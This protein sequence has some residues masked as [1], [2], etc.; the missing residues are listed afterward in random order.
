MV[1]MI[2]SISSIF[3]K[4]DYFIATY[5][6]CNLPANTL[7]KPPLPNNLQL[8][9]RSSGYIYYKSIKIS[10]NY[11]NNIANSAIYFLLFYILLS[12]FIFNVFKSW[13]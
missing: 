13:I 10:L 4:S 7:P 3:I 9:S 5:F 8:F 6:S 1:S 12:Y 2:V 11:T